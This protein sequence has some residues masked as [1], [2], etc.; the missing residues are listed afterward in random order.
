M[1]NENQKETTAVEQV[2]AEATEEATKVAEPV[3]EAAEE[4]T[5]KS[6]ESSKEDET[7]IDYKA[8]LEEE[9]NRREA[10]EKALADKAFKDREAKRKG[11]NQSEADTTSGDN[12][13]DKPLTRGEFLQL[14]QEQNAEQ[15]RSNQE[16]QIK[17]IIAENTGS[18][19]EAE[20]A[21]LMYQNRVV[22]TGNT[23]EDAMAAIGILNVRRNK[24]IQSELKRSVASKDTASTH[25]TD[26]TREGADREEPKLTSADASAIKAAGMKWNGKKGLYSKPLAG[27]K[28]TMY[29][30][31][32]R[33]SGQ[34]QWIA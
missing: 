10:A 8:I 4:S 24:A 11:Q 14:M 28:K 1:A 12:N 9:R 29:F 33:P 15:T 20:A 21:Y 34:K 18:E 17:Q 22:P 30:D 25:H 19:D 5:S 3:E 23:E 31:P 7:K 2:D 32:N 13:D 27:G 26:T 16:T 6:G